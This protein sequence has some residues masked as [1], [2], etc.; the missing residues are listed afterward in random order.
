[1]RKPILNSLLKWK[2]FFLYPAFPKQD[3]CLVCNKCSDIPRF[4]NDWAI[5]NF[6]CNTN[7]NTVLESLWPPV[8]WIANKWLCLF[9]PALLWCLVRRTNEWPVYMPA[10]GGFISFS[11]G[12]GALCLICTDPSSH[13]M[14][15]L[16]HSG[17]LPC[18]VVWNLLPQVIIWR[19]FTWKSMVQL[20]AVSLGF[21]SGT[22]R[23]LKR[24]LSF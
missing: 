14:P 8:H 1:M 18:V 20:T 13:V 10:C 4:Q 19:T 17:C 3:A 6:K 16:Y 2:Q 22:D 21:S 12:N 15:D 23:N 24:K 9:L 11:C 5:G 7:K